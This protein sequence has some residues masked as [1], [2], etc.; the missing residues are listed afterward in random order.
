MEVG[1]TSGAPDLHEVIVGCPVEAPGSLSHRDQSCRSL[2]PT[3]GSA[4]DRPLAPPRRDDTRGLCG[5]LPDGL[6][7]PPHRR[8]PLTGEGN[9]GKGGLLHRGADAPR[10][11]LRVPGEPLVFVCVFGFFLFSSYPSHLLYRGYEA[12]GPPALGP[13]GRGC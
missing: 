7:R 11:G 9:G 8:T 4:V 10:A 6:D 1:P 12:F 5:K 3:A 2:P 13:R